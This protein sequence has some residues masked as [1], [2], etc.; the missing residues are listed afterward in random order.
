MPSAIRGTMLPVL[1]TGALS[2]C[3][4]LPP[5]WG[6]DTP[7]TVTVR[8]IAGTSDCGMAADEPSLLVFADP[9]SLLRWAENNGRPELAADRVAGKRHAVVA[10][11]A[12]A[13]GLAV[14]R[15]AVKRGDHLTLRVSR[16]SA[17][18]DAGGAS[19]CAVVVL[20]ETLSRRARIELR[21]PGGRM[22]A[23]WPPPA[24]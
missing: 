11:D 15:E 20:P 4:G 5:M 10:M 19:A 22:L 12:A 16:L 14:A 3:S 2:A 1:L 9:G 21:G 24:E 18:P 17:G 23:F 6:D 13:G 8:Q 7:R